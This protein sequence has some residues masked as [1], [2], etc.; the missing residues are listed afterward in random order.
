[1]NFIIFGVLSKATVTLIRRLIT[2]FLSFERFF[3]LSAISFQLGVWAH[4]IERRKRTH[5]IANHTRFVLDFFFRLTW[6]LSCC[7]IVIILVFS[8]GFASLLFDCCYICC[9]CALFEC[10]G[11][12]AYQSNLSPSLYSFQTLWLI[13]TINIF[14]YINE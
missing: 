8:L 5:T 4:I 12:R 13:Y 6:K 7:L 11:L 2:Y 1:M 9:Y 14:V 3:F 10:L